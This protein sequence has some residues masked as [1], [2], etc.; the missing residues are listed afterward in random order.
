MS[1]FRSAVSLAAIAAM[2][3]AAHA[4]DIA[5]E[6]AP[7]ETVPYAEGGLP[8]VSGVN[9]KLAISAGAFSLDGPD[10]FDDLD[11]DGS[12]GL[13]NGALSIPL[14]HSFGLQ[15]DGLLGTLDGDM[16]AGVGGHLFWRDPATGLFGVY[17]DYVHYDAGGFGD[18]NTH[19]FGLEGEL[20]LGRFT[21]SGVA[22]MEG[23]DIDESFFD[24]I[25]LALYPTDDIKLYV[26]HRYAG[27]IHSAALGAEWQLPITALSGL[28]VF[29]EGRLGEDFAAGWG[30]IR[31]Y[32]GE[33][34]SLIRRHR[35]DDPV[36]RMPE[37]TSLGG[38]KGLGNVNCQEL[39]DDQLKLP[40]SCFDE[41]PG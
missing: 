2:T 13:L 16:V 5:Y 20:Y 4:A 8:A 27:D 28:S 21:I 22:G 32:F 7:I 31:V 41:F 38:L 33:S 12:I 19:R 3:G 17:G 14:G 29:G 39:F 1:I 36:E 6:P 37:I 35:E 18:V 15:V 25:D 30:G 24:M 11:V 40:E 10:D 34:K 26:G 23:G 9:G